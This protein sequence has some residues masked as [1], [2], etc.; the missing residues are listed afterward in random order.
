MYVISLYGS[1]AKTDGRFMILMRLPCAKW[2]IV[3][4]VVK[5]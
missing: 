5:S 4:L 1:V 3:C 2:Q